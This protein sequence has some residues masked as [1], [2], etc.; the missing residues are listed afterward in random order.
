[1]RILETNDWVIFNNITYQIHEIRDFDQMCLTFLQQMRLLMDFDAAVFYYSSKTCV[2]E[3]C[4]AVCLDYPQEAAEEYLHHYQE[5]DSSYG[6]LKGGKAM[7]YRASDMFSDEERT[8]TEYYHRFCEQQGLH[9]CVHL[10]PAMNGRAVA[11][12]TFFRSRNKSN[13]VYDDLFLLEMFKDHLALRIFRYY[14][15]QERQNEKLT[16]HQCE[17]HFHLTARE[18]TILGMLMQGLPND[19]ICEKLTITNN[20]LK[21]HILNTYK[22]M[23]IRNRTQLFKMVKEYGDD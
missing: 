14:D 11:K 3:L 4:H 17:E 23:S 22:K 2:P 8:G 6:L 20:T 5:C 7:V 12:I 19:E 21:K 10:I 16:V 1:M 18:T 15:E 13:F 9:H